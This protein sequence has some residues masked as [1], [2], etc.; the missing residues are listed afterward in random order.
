M[1]LFGSLGTALSGLTDLARAAAPLATT[2]AAFAPGPGSTLAKVGKAGSIL[3]N[4]PSPGA[5]QGQAVAIDSPMQTVPQETQGSG[6]ITQDMRM[7]PGPL[8]GY[9]PLIDRFIGTARGAAPGVGG[10]LA[11]EGG[12]QIL[13]Y[14]GGGQMQAGMAPIVNGKKLRVTRKL[15]MQVKQAVDL[16][17][18]EATATSMGVDPSVVLYIMTHKLRNDGPYVTK[19]AV[20]KTRSTIKKMKT[21]CDLYDDMRPAAKRSAPA[22]RRT[23]S[24]TL[25]KN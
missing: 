19:A 5:Q 3:S 15:K 21:M 12:A 25:I 24:T 11:F 16:I 6:T 7:L 13:D 23:S 22:R 1:A 8:G 17:G 2:A 18:V 14:L 4:L 20:R 9:A 10:A